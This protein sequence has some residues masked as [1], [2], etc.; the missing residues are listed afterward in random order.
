M[1]EFKKTYFVD[2][3]LNM[4]KMRTVKFKDEYDAKSAADTLIKFYRPGEINF[5][6][7]RIVYD[8]IEEENE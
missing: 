5:L 6:Q 2:F 1:D 4:T 8:K 7:I 3:Q